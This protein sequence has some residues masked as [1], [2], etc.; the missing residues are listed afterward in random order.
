MDKNELIPALEFLKP[1]K[2]FDGYY[3]SDL[4]KVYS[5][6]IKGGQGS[7]VINFMD[8]RELAYK[9]DK[10]GYKEVVLSKLDENGIHKRYY[11]RA[12]RLIY[13]TFYGKVNP[14]IDIDHKDQNKWNNNISNLQPL[15]HKINSGKRNTTYNF[16]NRVPLKVTDFN[17]NESYISTSIEIANN[18]NIS[19]Q[20]VMSIVARP[21]KQS[22]GKIKDKGIN[23]KIE[24]VEDIEKINND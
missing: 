21:D 22:F 5:A 3:C 11:K 24:R 2:D 4:G 20:N 23:I 14:S 1:I 6:K 15:S 19:R 10:D 9:Y 16:G 8:F 17:T 12:H 7:K 13:E 18:Y